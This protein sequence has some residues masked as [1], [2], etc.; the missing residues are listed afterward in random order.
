ME[1]DMF[2]AYEALEDLREGSDIVDDSSLNASVDNSYEAGSTSNITYH[3]RFVVEA[4]A[5]MGDRND[6][7]SFAEMIEPYI[8]EVIE[9]NQGN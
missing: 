7:E 4:G 5:M 8:S 1:K 3:Q 2:T 6:A 9:R